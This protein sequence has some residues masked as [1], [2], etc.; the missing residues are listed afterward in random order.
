MKIRTILLTGGLVLLAACSESKYDIDQLVPEEYHK[1]LY[2]NN[3]GKQEVTLYDTDADNLYTLSVIKSGSDPSLTAAANI[4][5]LTQVELDAKYSEPEAVN[6]QLIGADAY[7]LA[8]SSIDFSSADRYKLVTISL[9]PQVV[10]AAIESNPDAVW[11]LPLKV[12]SETDSIN[13]EKN[14]LFLQ[15]KA[16]ITPAVGFTDPTLVVQQYQYGSVSTIT[17]KVKFG[18]DTDNLWDLT[19]KLVVDN[20][21]VQEYNWDN[22]TNY[23]TLPE[24]SYTVPETAVLP[25]GTTTL[26]LE[27]SVNGSQLTPGDYMLPVKVA[28]VSQFEISEARAVYPLAIR[29]MGNKLDRTGWTAEADTEE[30]TGEGAGNGVAG[31]VLDDNLGTFWHSTWQ[32]GNRIPLPYEL[33]IDTKKEYTFTQLALMQRQHDTNR[34]TR[35][36]EFYISSDKENWTKVGSFNMQQILEAQTFG[37][38]PTKGRYV[39]IKMT[40]SFRD[41]Y[42]SLTEVYAYGLE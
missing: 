22:G 29:I 14:E 8:A 27:V 6:Y 12:T 7:S 4:L 42:C 11:V 2:V 32:T 33:I 20:D 34:D 36:G 25:S 10:K 21:Y 40:E 5:V 39:K 35:A 9:K 3:S 15:L 26:E 17:Q 30:L 18:L 1:I 13:A 41:G 23:K 19:A 38:T 24:G 16:V 28:E 37:V 31:C